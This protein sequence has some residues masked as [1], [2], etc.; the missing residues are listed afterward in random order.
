MNFTKLSKGCSQNHDLSG[1]YLSIC[2][3]NVSFKSC[4]NHLSKCRVVKYIMHD[5]AMW[6]LQMRV[7]NYSYEYGLVRPYRVCSNVELDD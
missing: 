6:T 3:C 4:R 7:K 5:V 2:T 1:A